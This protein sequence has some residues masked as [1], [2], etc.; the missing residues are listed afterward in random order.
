MALC[1]KSGT[2]V[3]TLKNRGKGYFLYAKT[4]TLNISS[5]DKTNDDKMLAVIICNK[6]ILSEGVTSSDDYKFFVVYFRYKQTGMM[7]KAGN[8]IDA[9]INSKSFNHYMKQR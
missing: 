5:S 3:G 8:I 7:P 1:T 6:D 2:A 4:G 9:I